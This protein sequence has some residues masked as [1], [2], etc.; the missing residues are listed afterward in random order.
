MSGAVGRAIPSIGSS[1]GPAICCRERATVPPD[2]LVGWDD[3]RTDIHH[4]LS[5][6][7][8][9]ECYDMP[10]FIC[11]DDEQEQAWQRVTLNW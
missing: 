5:V 8:M 4:W 7:I 9:I 3:G 6:M 1:V 2:R 10:H 11:F